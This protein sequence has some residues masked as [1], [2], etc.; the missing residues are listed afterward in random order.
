MKGLLAT[1][2]VLAFTVTSAE[3][4]TAACKKRTAAVQK[5]LD[6]VGSF[7]DSGAGLFE[8]K[9]NVPIKMLKEWLIDKYDAD[10]AEEISL[11]DWAESFD[12]TEAGTTYA[13]VGISSIMNIAETW[14]V[15]NSEEE[16]K[17]KLF[18][19]NLRK[20]ARKLVPHRLIW[21]FDGTDQGWGGSPGS[22][23]LLIDKECKV[24]HS[25]FLGISHD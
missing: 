11:K 14:Y 3:A 21:G 5:D 20:A 23:V 15:D 25:L 6:A 13:R 17:N 19:D 1:L 22:N 24:V 10:S 9:S 2:F 8:T 12:D 16:D 18:L 7:I 4:A